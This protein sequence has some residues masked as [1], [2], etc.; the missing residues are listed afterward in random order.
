MSSIDEQVAEEVEAVLSGVR[1]LQAIGAT[2]KRHIVRDEGPLRPHTRQADPTKVTEVARRIERCSVNPSFWAALRELDR[3]LKT[4]V[5][6][7]SRARPFEAIAACC[8]ASAALAAAT[9]AC[10]RGDGPDIDDAR[11]R[12]GAVE[13]RLRAHYDGT[14]DFSDLAPHLDHKGP[15]GPYAK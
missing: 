8:R 6:R 9:R 1:Q 10:G 2:A 3:E 12:Y 14:P 7:A 11:A 5:D 15:M 4:A 13:S